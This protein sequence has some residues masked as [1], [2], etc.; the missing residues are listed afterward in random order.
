M[1]LVIFGANGPTGR[2]ATQQALAE[3]HSVT[4]VTRRPEALASAPPSRS[5]P[6]RAPRAT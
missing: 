3:G 6:P 4:A 1:K 5:S 2:L